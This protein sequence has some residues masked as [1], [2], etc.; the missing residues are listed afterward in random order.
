[1]TGRMICQARKW[2]QPSMSAARCMSQD[3]LSS[4]HQPHSRLEGEL[5]QG[6]AAQRV[7]AK[8]ANNR[9]IVAQDGNAGDPT[10]NKIDG[11]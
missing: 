5:D 2:L 3:T 1:M 9:D 11:D 6:H 7:V 10:Q 8:A 4:L